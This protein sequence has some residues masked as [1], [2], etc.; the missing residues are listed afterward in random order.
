MVFREGREGEVR[1]LL[2]RQSATSIALVL[3]DNG[4]GLPAESGLGDVASLGLRLVRAL[5]QQLQAPLD[6]RSQGGTE[7]KLVFTTK[8]KTDTA[9]LQSSRERCTLT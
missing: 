6:I 9:E 8:P 2:R 7:V 1:I 4:V 3:S 5:A